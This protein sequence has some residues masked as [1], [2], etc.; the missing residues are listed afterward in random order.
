MLSN[1][2][3]SSEELS[4][5]TKVLNDYCLSNGVIDSAQRSQIARTLI[6]LFGSG[7]DSEAG[8]RDGLLRALS[9]SRVAAA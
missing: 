4:V 8:L 7:I 6:E 5:L 2:V 3:A 9:S 1:V